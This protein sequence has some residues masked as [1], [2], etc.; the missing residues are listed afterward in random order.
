MTSIVSKKQGNKTYLYAVESARVDGKPRIVSQTYLGSSE[1]VLAKLTGAEASGTTLRSAHHTFGDS[2]AVWGML[3]SL[4][5]AKIIDDVVSGTDPVKGVSVG[6]FLAIAALNRVVAPCSKAQIAD[7]WATTAGPRFTKISAAKLDH[8]RFWD[9]MN[10]LTPTHLEDISARIAARIVKEHDLDT[11]AL[12]LDMTNFATWVDT[13]ND[14]AALLARGKSKQKRAD[15]RLLGLGLVVTRDGSVP[16]AWHPYPGNR[17]DVSVFTQTL[18]TLTKS[19][20]AITGTPEP[21]QDGAVVPGYEGMTVVFD[22]GQNSAKNFTHLIN[23]GARY[24][25]STPPSD[26]Q[27]LLKVPKTRFTAVE[28]YP[29]VTAHETTKTVYGHAQ[30]IVLTHSD[31][32][33]RAQSRGFDQTLAKATAKLEELADTLTR[34]KSRRNA[35]ALAAH[36]NSIT[37]DTW[38]N[39]VLHTTL[40][41]DTP[42][43]FI[44]T[45]TVDAG[46]RK[47]LEHRV[48]GKRILI[49]NQP[50]W[51]PA[52]IVAAYRSQSHVEDSFRQLK[53]RQVVSFSPMHHWTDDHIRVHTFTCVL[54]L[55]IAHL[56]TRT[57]AKA[58][59]PLSTRALL[60]ELGSIQET[61]LLHHDGAKGRPRAQRLLTEHSKTAEKLSGLFTLE[62]YAPNR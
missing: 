47:K 24:V 62:T 25:G 39:E 46:A 18:N 15:L 34:G 49:T 42:A 9:A 13:N 32:L 60:D 51:S 33:H 53:D 1:E 20:H 48:F 36:I 29:G 10:Q 17:P 31:T 8:R 27:E 45:H 57:A 16:L 14:A 44:L 38:V 30:R 56:M 41:G 19:F 21:T 4:G 54:A 11:S 43:T 35:T 26:H 37:H 22:A 7:W 2:A 52:Q 5:I 6:Q 40:T 50:D 59:L 23:T 58:G 3:E 12:A 28:D 55:Q 61:V